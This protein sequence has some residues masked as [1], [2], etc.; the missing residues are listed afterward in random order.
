MHENL[1]VIPDWIAISGRLNDGK[2]TLQDIQGRYQLHHS[3]EALLLYHMIDDLDLRLIMH[4]YAT[5]HSLSS[6]SSH[7][8][9]ADLY[10]LDAFHLLEKCMMIQN[11]VDRVVQTLHMRPPSPIDDD[12]QAAQ[13]EVAIQ[14]SMLEYRHA[15]RNFFMIMSGYGENP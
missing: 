9:E 10:S 8:L 6:A 1:V 7:Q 12:L 5:L 3:F 15:H 2:S 11:H 13:W 4:K 14:A